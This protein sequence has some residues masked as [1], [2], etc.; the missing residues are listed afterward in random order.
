MLLMLFTL[1]AGSNGGRVM[2]SDDDDPM[3]CDPLPPLL[4]EGRGGTFN[5]VTC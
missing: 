1:L 3:L 2:A 5:Y 4:C